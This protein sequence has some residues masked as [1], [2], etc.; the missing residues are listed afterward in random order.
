MTY[1]SGGED[2][3]ETQEVREGFSEVVQPESGA[4]VGGCQQPVRCRAIFWGAAEKGDRY[5]GT[6]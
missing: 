2:G 6:T 5:G 4:E 3:T 1:T